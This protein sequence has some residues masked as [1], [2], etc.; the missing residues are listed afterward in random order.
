MQTIAIASEGPE[1]KTF[2]V[3]EQV[4]MVEAANLNDAASANVVI[5]F[6]GGGCKKLVGDAAHHF[7]QAWQAHLASGED[8]P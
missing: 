6:A 3:L 4:C 1:C 7:L 5:T 2:V 8:G